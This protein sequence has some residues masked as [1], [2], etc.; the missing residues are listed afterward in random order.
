MNNREKLVEYGYED[1]IVYQNPS[2]DSAIIGVDE[3][4]GSVIYDYE[5]MVKD[6]MHQD[7]ITQEQA[8]QF[9]DYNTVRATSYMP[10][11]KPIILRRLY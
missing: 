2:F 4:T 1:A 3:I 8:I 10:Q 7:N 6:M 5:L 11:P 9:I